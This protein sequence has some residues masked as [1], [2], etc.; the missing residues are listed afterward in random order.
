MSAL[1]HS[2]SKNC[3][4]KDVGIEPKCSEGWIY[5]L[6]AYI[7]THKD[8]YPP[9]DKGK[10]KWDRVDNPAVTRTL[11][12]KEMAPGPVVSESVKGRKL[13]QTKFLLNES[14][15]QPRRITGVNK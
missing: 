2:G 11:L 13:K 12:A 14:S 7:V 5:R 3:K 1:P 6:F 9:G 8:D 4:A 10:T 15:E